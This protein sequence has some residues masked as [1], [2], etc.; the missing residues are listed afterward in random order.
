MKYIYCFVGPSGSGKSTIV[1]MLEQRGYT[2][3]SSYTDRPP[4]YPGEKGHVFL[5]PAEF[6]KLGELCA[7]TEFCG[8]RYGVTADQIRDNDLYIIDVDGVVNHPRLKPWACG[9][10]R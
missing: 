1:E 8:H 7:Y 9:E 4:R 3:V 10:N 2:A 5:T 6:D